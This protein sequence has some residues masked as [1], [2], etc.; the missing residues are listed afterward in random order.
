MMET[1]KK[2]KE[3]YRKILIEE[4]KSLIKKTKHTNFMVTI[5]WCD[6]LYGKNLIQHIFTGACNTMNDRVLLVEKEDS[7]ANSNL[8][9]DEIEDVEKIEE[10][11]RLIEEKNEKLY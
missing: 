11:Y 6:Y 7:E 3:T 1:I 9:L 2:A 5:G 4:V 10:I 8:F